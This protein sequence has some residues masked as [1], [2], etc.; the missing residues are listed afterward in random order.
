MLSDFTVFLSLEL[1]ANLLVLSAIYLA[2]RKI[3]WHWLVGFFSSVLFVVIFWKTK[4]YADASLNVL[5]CVFAVYGACQWYRSAQS[6]E[7]F[8]V[9]RISPYA[10]IFWVFVCM[11]LSFFT[12]SWLG[13]YT[14]S[15][16]PY[17]DSFA[18]I[19][20]LLATHM[21]VRKIRENWIL[22]ILINSVYIYIY[23]SQGLYSTALMCVVLIGLCFRGYA[24]WRSAD[25]AYAYDDTPTSN[26]RRNCSV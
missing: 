8:Y 3:Y 5:Y 24:Q 15:P 2:A 18:A 25:L 26:G 10:F 19:A 22:W 17:L 9:Y 7:R 16:L 23:T 4:L 1:S 21:L 6:G 20:S 12:G 14:D 11:L 13:S